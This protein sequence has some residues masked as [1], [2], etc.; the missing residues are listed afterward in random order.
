MNGAGPTPGGSETVAGNPYP[1]FEETFPEWPIP[2]T[3]EGTW[4]LGPGGTLAGTP[5][6]AEGVDSYTSNASATPLTDYLGPLAKSI[7]GCIDPRAHVL[8]MA[9]VE[10]TAVRRLIAEVDERV[11]DEKRG[12]RLGCGSQLRACGETDEGGSSDQVGSADIPHKMRVEGTGLGDARHGRVPC[13]RDG[14]HQKRIQRQADAQNDSEQTTHVFCLPRP[15]D[16]TGAMIVTPT[17]KKSRMGA[18]RA[19]VALAGP[20]RARASRAAEA[21]GGAQRISCCLATAL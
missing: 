4:Y 11:Q 14:E 3:K 12:T 16:E 6:A 8:D 21:G 1:A 17:A 20:C 19:R 7:T 10:L 5:A 18:G 15:H 2:E 13:G 9:S